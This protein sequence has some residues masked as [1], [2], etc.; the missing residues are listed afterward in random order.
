MIYSVTPGHVS[1][2]GV[3]TYQYQ[4]D[5]VFKHKITF[6][7][8]TESFS[9]LLTFAIPGLQ[10]VPSI[11]SIVKYAG[12]CTRLKRDDTVIYHA[13]AGI[14]VK[15]VFIAWFIPAHRFSAI[16]WRDRGP[17]ARL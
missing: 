15:E 1:V 17:R 9:D 11:A 10:R 14:Q 16:G 7:S 8:S 13:T 12:F 4:L 3:G 5:R 6:V 2:G